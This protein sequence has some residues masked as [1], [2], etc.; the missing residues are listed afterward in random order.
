MCVSVC[1]HNVKE[2]L[3]H[4]RLCVCVCVCVCVLDVPNIYACTCV[5]VHLDHHHLSSQ[6][7]SSRICNTV[8]ISGNLKPVA[9]SSEKAIFH[10]MFLCLH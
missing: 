1:M 5:S 7:G 3:D 8:H 9:A 6:T 4:K 2:D 10:W